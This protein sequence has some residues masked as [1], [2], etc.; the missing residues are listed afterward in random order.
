MGQIQNA[1]ASLLCT[2]KTL[3]ATKCKRGEGRFLCNLD[4]AADWSVSN[5][6]FRA[7][8]EYCWLSRLVSGMALN[9]GPSVSQIPITLPTTRR[10]PKAVPEYCWLSR[11]VSGMAPDQA[12]SVLPMALPTV[13][14]DTL[15][16]EGANFHF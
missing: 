4:K 12:P 2:T 13:L 15:I 5:P 1:P 14:G 10:R 3:S 16:F 11:L 7:V 9:Q 6:F 8:P